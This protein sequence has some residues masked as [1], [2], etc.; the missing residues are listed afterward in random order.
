[1]VYLR[2]FFKLSVIQK[3]F[4]STYWKKF[5][6]T[7][8]PVQCKTMCS[9]VNCSVYVARKIPRTW[10][11]SPVPLQIHF[12]SLSI[13]LRAPEGYLVQKTSE[14]FLELWLPLEV[15]EE[16]IA[17]RRSRSGALPAAGWL[18]SSMEA[19]VSAGSPLLGSCRHSFLFPVQA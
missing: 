4:Y 19:T 12:R 16:V 18:Y 14:G 15:V 1:M 7:N 2:V 11:H 9:G 8:G 6:Q 10:W 3:F 13:L 5:L 17:Q